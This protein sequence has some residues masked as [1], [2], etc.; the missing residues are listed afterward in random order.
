M[1]DVTEPIWIRDDVVQAIHQQQ[2]KEHGGLDGLRDANLLESALVRPRNLLAYG[3]PPPDL[4]ALAA[5][6]A[7]GIVRNHPYVDGNK[8]T[9]LIV[10][11]TCLLQNG[12]DIAATQAEKVQTFLDLAAGK[13]S[14]EVLAAWLRERMLPMRGE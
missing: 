5:A 6:Y 8:R 10:A 9:G 3:D 4:A 13:L 14:E 12:S 7:Y 1:P 11:R 2:I